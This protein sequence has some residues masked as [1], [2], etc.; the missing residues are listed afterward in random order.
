MT[1]K[2]LITALAI[3]GAP[4]ALC[5][6]DVVTD[7]NEITLQTIRDTSTNPPKATRVL[8]CVHVAIYDAVNAVDGTHEPYLSGIAPAPKA[9]AEAAAA[10]AAH[11]EL[12]ALYPD[13]KDTFDAALV[14]SLAAIPDGQAKNDG[15]AL[16][17]LCADAIAAQREDDGAS[18]IVSY[19]PGDTPE[20]WQPT[21]PAMAPALLPNWPYVTC[22]SIAS[23]EQF[24]RAGPP[25]LTS[26][27]YTEAFN[28][29]KSLGSKTS[30]ERT[31]EQ[32]EIAKFWSDGGGT[33][34]PPGHWN[35][36]ARIVAA[37]E[38]NTLA[39]N[40]RLFA[41]LNIA[42]ADAAISCWDNKYAYNHVRPITA[43]R[44]AADD[45]NP[46]TEADP[47]WEPLI[48][49][50][51]FPT[52]TSGHGTF[53][54]AASTILAKFYGTDKITFTAGSDG[55]PG[56]QRTFHSFSEA[57]D[58]AAASR[59]YG[60]IHWDYDNYDGLSAGRE[61]AA[62]VYDKSLVAA[63]TVDDGE[64][65]PHTLC[66]TL[67]FGTLSIMLTMMLVMRGVR[68]G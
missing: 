13:L 6:A 2:W 24:R 35:T 48:T 50:P 3:A 5:S 42:L 30:T 43:I 11:D 36:V 67:G 39:Q 33:E 4:T 7:W 63:A 58:E 47:A 34:T 20:E 23:G 64:D 40:A 9:S 62:Y 41:L 57:A 59:L 22:W 61:L 19:T 27:R 46:D 1:R 49:T 37:Q 29:V 51:P 53:S 56:V 31:E 52:Y 25:A 45:G 32:T 68:R 65:T 14:D 8:A 17:S 18:V 10:Q 44:N 66:G 15:I 26:Q 55:L 21:P 60:G 54:G 12:V 28:H 38:G 16:G